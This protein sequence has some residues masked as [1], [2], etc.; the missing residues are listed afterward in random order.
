MKFLI[1][2]FLFLLI[3][4][5]GSQGQIQL[6]SIELSGTATKSSKSLESALEFS[7][8]TETLC[9]LSTLERHF[10]KTRNRF[11][12]YPKFDTWAS[13]PSTSKLRY[14]FKYNGYAFENIEF[15]KCN[16][17]WIGALEGMAFAFDFSATILNS[18]GTYSLTEG[19]K[20]PELDFST[21]MFTL[22][23]GILGAIIGGNIESEENYTRVKKNIYSNYRFN[24]DFLFFPENHPEMKRIRNNQY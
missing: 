6:K 4:I 2:V 21:G 1:S 20:S 8:Y 12:I 17:T 16:Q 13:F 5:G 23:G 19:A 24:E 7:S 3:F 11:K 14:D 18:Y 15:N 22:L 9:D 10:S